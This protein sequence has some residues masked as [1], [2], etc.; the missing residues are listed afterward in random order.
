MSSV[1]A[2]AVTG[3]KAQLPVPQ[4]RVVDVML[5]KKEGSQ[6]ALVTIVIDSITRISGVS[7]FS[8]TNELGVGL[9]HRKG[10]DG[11]WYPVVTLLTNAAEQELRRVVLEAYEAELAKKDIPQEST[12]VTA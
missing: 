9:P 10:N 12:P 4:I 8:R 6:K 5:S 7:V 11:N 1:K 2:K 3:A